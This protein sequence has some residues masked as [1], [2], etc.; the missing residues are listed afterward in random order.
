MATHHRQLVNLKTWHHE[1]TISMKID[2]N[3]SSFLATCFAA[4]LLA[5]FACLLGTLIT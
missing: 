3:F 1:A 5:K 2:S 4:V